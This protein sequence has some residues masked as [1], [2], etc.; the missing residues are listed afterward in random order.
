LPFGVIEGIF[1][2]FRVDFLPYAAVLFEDD[3]CRVPL[4][5]A[6]TALI[7]VEFLRFFC[8]DLL[9]CSLLLVRL[10]E[11]FLIKHARLTFDVSNLS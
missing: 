2:L 6:V 7:C 10:F 1:L 3:F 11:R 5:V 4:D 8:V 9:F